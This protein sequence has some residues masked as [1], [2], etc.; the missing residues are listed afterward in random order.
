M[1]TW[2]LLAGRLLPDDFLRKKVLPEEV[3]AEEVVSEEV[4][5]FRTVRV[6]SPGEFVRAKSPG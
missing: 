6:K 1:S 2:A 3:V 5:G 4:V